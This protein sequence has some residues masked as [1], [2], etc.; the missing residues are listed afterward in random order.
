MSDQQLKHFIAGNIHRIQASFAEM[1]G[2]LSEYAV[3]SQWLDLGRALVAIGFPIGHLLTGQRIRE[4]NTGH[5]TSSGGSRAEA[6]RVL[7]LDANA[8]PEEIKR[9]YREMTKKFHPDVHAGSSRDVQEL[10]EEKMR[11]VNAAYEVLTA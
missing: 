10:A 9:A 1:N 2:L 7:G 4:P 11:Q 3:F 6:L 8:T 5:S